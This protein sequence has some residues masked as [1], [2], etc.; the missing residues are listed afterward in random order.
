MKKLHVGSRNRKEVAVLYLHDVANPNLVKT[1][2]DRIKTI[3]IDT[4]SQGADIELRIVERKWS[5]FPLT[6]AVQRVDSTVQEISQGKVVVI[7]DGDPTV[8]IVP[9][10]IQDF[11]QTE[12]D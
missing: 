1:V 5:L 12:E 2:V 11:F 9:V 6:R 7:V 4:V 3:E 10:T 8:F